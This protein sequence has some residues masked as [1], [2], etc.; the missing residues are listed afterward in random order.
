MVIPSCSRNPP[1]PPSQLEAVPYPYHIIICY[2]YPPS[3]QTTTT[4]VWQ[5]DS[6]HL[7]PLDAER[8]R[9]NSRL[10][11]IHV[12]IPV[13]SDIIWGWLSLAAGSWNS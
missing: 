1:P 8:S 3:H 9:L 10:R 2:F 13:L 7:R 5:C 12:D 11:G 6:L 4:S